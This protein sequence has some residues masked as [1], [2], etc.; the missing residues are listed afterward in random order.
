MN[1][2]NALWLNSVA[3][4]V[5]SHRRVIDAAVV[6]LTDEELHR[7]PTQELNSVAVILRHLGGNLQSRWTDFL[8]TDGEKPDRNRELEF[9]DWD[10]DR[11][12]LMEYF[13][14]GWTCLESAMKQLT[15]TN[16]TQSIEIRGELHTIPEAVTRSITHIAYHVGQIVMI[17]R[18]V[19][20]EPWNWLTIA[21]G[22]SATFNEQ[23]WGTAASRGV[24][25]ESSSQ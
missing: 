14:A 20:K 4:T 24:Y 12:S 9:A 13:D 17:A 18:T 23:S 1:E 2:L 19:H 7:K 11:E 8:T 10:G 5:N 25:G 22:D 16:V 6:Q 15:D 21:P 3:S